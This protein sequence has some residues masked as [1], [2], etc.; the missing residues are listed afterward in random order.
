MQAIDS[1]ECGSTTRARRIGRPLPCLVMLLYAAA[2]VGMAGERPGDVAPERVHIYVL[3]GQSN[4]AGRGPVE[5]TDRQPH[6]RVFSYGKEHAWVP[7]VDPLHWDKPTAGVGPGSSFG[8]AMAEADPEILVGLVPCAVGGTALERWQKGGDL[9]TQAIERIQSASKDGTVQGVIWHQG[10]ADGLSTETAETYAE[11]LSN[12][13]QD[14]RAELHMPRLPFVAGQLGPFLPPAQRN[15]SP[16]Y[17]DV[18]QQQILQLPRLIEWTAVADATGLTHTGDSV[19]FDSASQ[20]EFGRRYAAAMQRLQLRQRNPAFAPFEPRP[21][22]PNVLLLG[23]SIS[24][25]YTPEVRRRLEGKANVFRPLENCRS[26]RQIL[27][28]I[29]QYVGAREWDVIHFN[30]G[31][32]DITFVNQA[33]EGAAA[34]QGTIQVPLSEYR[35]NLQRIVERLRATN[36]RLIWAATTPIGEPAQSSGIRSNADVVDYN[37]AAASIMSAAGIPQ[38]DL[39]SLVADRREELLD[40]G[41]HLNRAGIE[42]AST[43]VANA[44]LER[45]AASHG[46]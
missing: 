27:R 16:A 2:R 42:I 46:E 40:H 31:I 22:L 18:V 36:A 34:P 8:R 38:L 25:Q 30:A 5:E 23:D 7:A 43:A 17:W 15:G 3:M 35:E 29:E 39:Y 24:M 9:W 12:L 26:T 4:M 14:L 13:V 1:G 45:L 20:R 19:H 37:A 10:E 21:D 6:P 33:G 11:R 32:H 28:R 44:I 41:V